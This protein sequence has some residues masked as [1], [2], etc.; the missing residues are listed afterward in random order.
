MSNEL[1]KPNTPDSGFAGNGF[2]EYPDL[3]LDYQ[4]LHEASQLEDGTLNRLT[5]GYFKFLNRDD[6][7]P[8]HRERAQ[9]NF[10]RLLFEKAYRS[11]YYVKAPDDCGELDQ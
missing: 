2:E 7:M 6:V 1:V 10:R 8:H 9:A 5:N 3:F 4:R 11:G